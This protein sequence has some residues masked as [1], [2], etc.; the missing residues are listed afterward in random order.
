MTLS[1]SNSSYL[2]QLS[3]YLNEVIESVENWNKIK[4][5]IVSLKEMF[6]SDFAARANFPTEVAA[7]AAPV[8]NYVNSDRTSLA[9]EA[10]LLSAHLSCSLK[11][12][13]TPHVNQFCPA[14][15]QALGKSN[16]IYRLQGFNALSTIIDNVNSVL[17]IRQICSSII[18]Q[19]L[20]RRRLGAKLFKK[21]IV[22]FDALLLLQGCK[23]IEKA[24][25]KG[26]SDPILDIKKVFRS[27]FESYVLKLPV[28]LDPL[29]KSLPKEVLKFFDQS[30]AMPS[31]QI[32]PVATQFMKPAFLHS[33]AVQ[34]I[35]K[36]SILQKSSVP[37]SSNVASLSL[38][39]PKLQAKP[40][41]IQISK[42]SIQNH[43]I[44]SL[45]TKA[46]PVSSADRLQFKRGYI[47]NEKIPDFSHVKSR[48]NQWRIASPK[49]LKTSPKPKI[50][51]SASPKYVYSPTKAKVPSQSAEN[52]RAN[53]HRRMSPQK[54]E[55]SSGSLFLKQKPVADVQKH[56]SP[57]RN[58]S[59]S[60]LPP[61]SQEAVKIIPKVTGVKVCESCKRPFP[62]DEED[63]SP[64][65]FKSY[66]QSSLYNQD[67]ISAKPGP[68]IIPLNQ[69]RSTKPMKSSTM[70]MRSDS[71]FITDVLHE[72]VRS[73]NLKIN[74]PAATQVPQRELASTNL[75]P[76]ESLGPYL[77]LIPRIL[78]LYQGRKRS[79]I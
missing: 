6:T 19:S 47:I 37:S 50:I 33:S 78:Y 9:K 51:K 17:V 76:T 71:P 66:Y 64:K 44:P 60:Q 46:C 69:A 16:S 10:M 38:S 58:I 40:S 67:C 4:E 45:S 39:F 3:H 63:P 77:N 53:H 1:T 32:V 11:K 56:T 55:S 41:S 74:S 25:S 14:L 2:S 72:E 28:R 43:S 35:K 12:G 79:S 18:S 21:L 75:P 15:I 49:A 73:R 65:K 68:S 59:H 7:I 13:F 24:F 36:S 26:L 62:L 57:K 42:N 29:I 23:D 8:V 48:V 27:A 22:S 61:L 31:A 52:A 70:I 5:A 30:K 34:P 54:F 20:D